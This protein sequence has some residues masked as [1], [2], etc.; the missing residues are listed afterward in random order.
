M[1]TVK[2]WQDIQAKAWG[3]LMKDEM[4]DRRLTM[5]FFKRYNISQ[6]ELEAWTIN[7]LDRYSAT[8]GKEANEDLIKF[9]DNFD[10]EKGKYNDRLLAVRNK[11]QQ[12]VD[13]VQA[14]GD[15]AF[16]RN[17]AEAG[18]RYVRDWK[19]QI[20]SIEYKDLKEAYLFSEDFWLKFWKP[21]IEC[22]R[23]H[24]SNK[25]HKSEIDALEKAAKYIIFDL[26]ASDCFRCNFRRLINRVRYWQFISSKETEWIVDRCDESWEDIMHDRDILL[27]AAGGLKDGNEWKSHH[28]VDPLPATGVLSAERKQAEKDRL[29]S[30]KTFIAEWEAVDPKFYSVKGGRAKLTKAIH[31]A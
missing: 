27:N 3:D 5:G 21:Q 22:A 16:S 6:K 30:I 7:I 28:T 2:E 1:K 25:E 15:Y 8:I 11:F 10:E 19:A 13:D 24:D 31:K 26:G 4:D 23:E 14:L 17:T 18:D 9:C 29:E 20:T 12:A